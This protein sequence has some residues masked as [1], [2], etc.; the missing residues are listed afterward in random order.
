MCS[1]G[2]KRCPDEA[3]TDLSGHKD[4]GESIF[5]RLSNAAEHTDAIAVNR[6]SIQRPGG[7]WAPS[8]P[9]FP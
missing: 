5:R 7:L 6:S 3:N 8:G 2:K 4:Q 1:R 9:T